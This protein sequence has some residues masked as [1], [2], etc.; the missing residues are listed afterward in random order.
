MRTGTAPGS[1]RSRSEDRRAARSPVRMAFMKR[2]VLVP[3]VS[4]TSDSSSIAA[5]SPAAAQ[6]ANSSSVFLSQAS[7]AFFGLQNFRDVRATFQPLSAERSEATLGTRSRQTSIPFSGRRDLACVW[8]AVC[9]EAL[10]TREGQDLPMNGR[11]G[12]PKLEGPLLGHFR[13]PFAI[14]LRAMRRQGIEGGHCPALA[15]AGIARGGHPGG[16][17]AHPGAG[18]EDRDRGV[19]PVG[20]PGL[21]ASRL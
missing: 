1:S 10:L 8:E 5:L 2:K 15:R 19:R 4:T 11:E 18:Q 6:E 12:K 20:V 9:P 7:G 16:R 13:S 21:A 14:L 17:A 3:P